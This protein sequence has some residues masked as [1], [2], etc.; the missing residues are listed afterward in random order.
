M[1]NYYLL[2]VSF[3]FLLVG[4]QDAAELAVP[5]RSA[6]HV[7]TSLQSVTTVEGFTTPMSCTT[8]TL[9][10]GEIYQICKP[11]NW[12]GELIIYAHGYISEFEPL[13]LPT[14]ASKYAPLFVSQ[15]YAFATTSYSQ[16]GLAIQ[17][18]IQDIIRLREKFIQA[19][20][21]PKHI[22]LTGASEGGILTTLALE[23]YPNL[24]SGGLSLCGPC[25]YFQGQINY[26]GDF[27]VLFDYFFPGVLPGNAIT[28]PDELIANWQTK[29]VPAVLK[30]LQQNPVATLKLLRTSLAPYDANDPT[31]IGQTVLGVL[32]YDVVYYRDA[33][34]K[35]G[36]Q[37]IDNRTRIYFGTGSIA[38]DFRLNAKVQRFKADR[39][40]TET[41]KKYYETSGNLK[42][43][44]VMAHTSKDPIILAWH[45][46]LYQAKTY[47]KGT[48]GYFT[49][50]PVQR[51]GHC[52]FTDAEIVTGL[53][54]L[55]QKIQ[56]QQS[57]AELV[58]AQTGDSSG[59]II[60]AVRIIR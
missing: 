46:P 38:E 14:E 25:G 29:Y 28:I 60:Q 50:I 53:G 45:L 36:G 6:D 34:R 33:Y 58:L 40:A 31:T 57:Q 22:Y 51:Y 11:A 24:F 19:N 27:R 21:Q 16:N 59:K 43:P 37:P 13:Q 17:T 1:K 23:R 8:E 4:C 12:N 15:G 32:R 35:L 49:G 55:L 18:G 39:T 7:V 44:L 48:N 3:I 20:G 10:T 2:L 52:T 47:L 5:A 54:L 9:P 41:I 30:A 42:K 26:Y 56:G